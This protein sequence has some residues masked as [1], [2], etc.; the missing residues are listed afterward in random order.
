MIKYLEKKEKE[1]THESSSHSNTAWYCLCGL[2]SSIILWSIAIQFTRRFRF[3]YTKAIEKNCGNQ[4]ISIS[5]NTTKPVVPEN[6]PGMTVSALIVQSP[7]LLL[8]F[9]SAQGWYINHLMCVDTKCMNLFSWV[10]KVY[11]P[12]KK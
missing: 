10:L 11:P 5:K 7:H 3:K 12:L 1:L 6:N 2:E 9:T 4:L 8:P